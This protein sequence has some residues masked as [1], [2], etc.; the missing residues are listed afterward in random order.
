VEAS[1][2]L[3]STHIIREVGKMALAKYF[4]DNCEIS[5]ERLY[6]S[7]EINW[8]IDPSEIEDKKIQTCKTNQKSDSSY[9]KLNHGGTFNANT[10]YN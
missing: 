6:N 7:S 3:T 10:I 1:N 2:Y 9:S 8:W 5:A 4:E